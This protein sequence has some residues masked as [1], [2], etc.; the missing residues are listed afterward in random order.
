MSYV[1]GQ[2]SRHVF[3]YGSLMYLPVWLKV[4]KGIYRCENGVATGFQR[5]SVPG[6]AYPAMV[7]LEGA[8]VQGMV[9][10]DVLP[11]D[12]HRLD[13][14][15]GEEYE[16]SEI[17][18]LL[19]SDGRVIKAD[20]YMWLNPSVLNEELWSVSHFETEGILSFLDRHVENWN[21]NGKR[22]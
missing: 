17:D 4:V 19:N 16:R 1:F 21:I 11:D 2:E 18:V 20:T 8:Y 14:F 13:A 5:H 22:K 12:L 6:E 10:F 9:W 7:P 3:V 15:E